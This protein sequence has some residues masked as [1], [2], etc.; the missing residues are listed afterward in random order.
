MLSLLHV[1]GISI[2]RINNIIRVNHHAARTTHTP[3][4]VLYLYKEII[5]VPEMRYNIFW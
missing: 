4:R 3:I 1:G 2:I 5:H